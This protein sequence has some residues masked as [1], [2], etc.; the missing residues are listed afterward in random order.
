MAKN[1]NRQ[2][3]RQQ[4][5]QMSGRRDAQSDATQGK[6]QDRGP[7]RQPQSADE[8]GNIADDSTPRDAKGRFVSSVRGE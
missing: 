2:R 7:N 1:K 3:Q 4:P 6:D 8:D 5:Q